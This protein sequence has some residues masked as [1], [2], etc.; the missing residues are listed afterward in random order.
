MGSAPRED[1]GVRHRLGQV[2][3]AKKVTPATWQRPHCARPHVAR[4]GQDSP[5]AGG[6]GPQPTTSTQCRSSI[7]SCLGPPTWPCTPQVLSHRSTT[8]AVAASLRRRGISMRDVASASVGRRSN[9]RLHGTTPERRY[10]GVSA[11]TGA[12][13]RV[14]A[15][16]QRFEA[17][18]DRLASAHMLQRAYVDELTGALR[19][20]GRST[21]V[22]RPPV[23]TGPDTVAGCLH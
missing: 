14:V 11:G 23:R 7:S 2:D 19:R 18:V 16:R 9:G 1:V 12:E 10:A 5:P 21:C 8:H 17:A 3:T 13:H 15:A 22:T 4:R 6:L 20:D